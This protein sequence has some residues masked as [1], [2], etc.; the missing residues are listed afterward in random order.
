MKIFLFFLIAY[1]ITQIIVD[2]YLLSNVRSYVQSK[3]R[4]L[5]TL[6]TCTMCTG[7]WVGCGLSVFIWS[8]STEYFNNGATW[9]SDGF[10]ISAAV[11][12]IYCIENFFTRK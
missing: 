6:V 7:F 4:L 1:G 12:L 3:S 2:S 8:P 9:I 5:Y 11:W 10:L